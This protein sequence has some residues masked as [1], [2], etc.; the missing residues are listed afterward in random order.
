MAR[1]RILAWCQIP[2][3]VQATDAPGEVARRPM[4]KWF[5]QE[6]SRIT[7]REGLAGT[8][9]YLA[10]FAWSD[11]VER[12]GRQTRWLTPS[13]SRWLPA[14]EGPRTAIVCFPGPTAGTTPPPERPAGAP[15]AEVASEAGGS[16][17]GS[18]GR[19]YRA[20]GRPLRAHAP[21]PPRTDTVPSNPWS[22]RKL[23]AP[24][25][26]LPDAQITA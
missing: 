6:I 1:Y 16:L 12:E 8:D 11:E 10:E 19:A 3:Q 17:A 21:V 25:L 20:I 9:D 18:A 26:R 13:W 5:M 22:S 7:M 4:P 23:V 24:R 2:T 15:P 14:G